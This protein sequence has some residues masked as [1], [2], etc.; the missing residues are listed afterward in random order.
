MFQLLHR[1]ARVMP[2]HMIGK[3]G[4]ERDE[5][6]RAGMTTRSL[7][8]SQA[9]AMMQANHMWLGVNWPDLF[10]ANALHRASVFG[11]EWRWSLPS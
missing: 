2:P 1:F 7:C 4:D 5:R 11:S 6:L 9:G 10:V 8:R 3:I